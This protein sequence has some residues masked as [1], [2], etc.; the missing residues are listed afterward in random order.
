MCLHLRLLPLQPCVGLPI[1]NILTSLIY[2]RRFCE[3]IFAS[4]IRSRPATMALSSRES[5]TEG[6]LCCIDEGRRLAPRQLHSHWRPLG[7]PSGLS[8]I[9][10]CVCEATKCLRVWRG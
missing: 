1:H 4:P 3:V 9:G 8:M 5:F 7:F 6:Y 10:H 2:Q